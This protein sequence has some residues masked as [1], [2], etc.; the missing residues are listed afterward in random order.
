MTNVDHT[1]DD[2]YQQVTSLT[3]AAL[4]LGRCVSG[5]LG[6]TLVSLQVRPRQ[7]VT[8]I[9]YYNITLLMLQVCDYRQLNYISLGMVTAATA[10]SFLLPPVTSTIYFHNTGV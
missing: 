9:Y 4:L 8:I 10:V 3:R 5:A 2:C 6:Q 7:N 1:L